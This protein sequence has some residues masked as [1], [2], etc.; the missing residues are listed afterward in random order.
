MS[1][2]SGVANSQSVGSH[3]QSEWLTVG[4]TESDRYLAEIKVSLDRAATGELRRVAEIAKWFSLRFDAASPPRRRGV[5]FVQTW[6]IV[7]ESMPTQAC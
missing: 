5:S 2:D 6:N 3:S 4:S 7:R 1:H